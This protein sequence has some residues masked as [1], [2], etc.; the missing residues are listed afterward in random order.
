[1][2]RRL[3]HARRL[4]RLQD[5]ADDDRSE[6]TEGP[7]NDFYRYWFGDRRGLSIWCH[8]RVR[9]PNDASESIS[10]TWFE[11]CWLFQGG[12]DWKVLQKHRWGA[13]EEEAE[14][15][16]PRLEPSGASHTSDSDTEAMILRLMKTAKP[17][18][19]SCN[20]CAHRSLQVAQPSSRRRR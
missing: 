18:Q 7:G 9:R 6:G 15:E 20:R 19:A 16:L 4:S 1:M 3:G 11:L 2:R 8:D 5:D 14:E 13:Y 10:Q 12:A 17:L